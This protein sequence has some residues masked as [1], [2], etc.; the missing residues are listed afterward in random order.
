MRQLV[1]AVLPI[2]IGIIYDP[3]AGSAS[4]L[5]A[6]KAV[7]YRAI[8]TD[9]VLEYVNMGRRAFADLARIRV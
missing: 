6:A 7:G 4:T 8:G 1:P 5:A 2:G 3:F 9:R